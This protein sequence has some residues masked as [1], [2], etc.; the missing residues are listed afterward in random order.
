[1]DG[2][3]DNGHQRL[4]PPPYSVGGI[5]VKRH[6]TFLKKCTI[7]NV[8]Y[9]MRQNYGCNDRIHGVSLIKGVSCASVNV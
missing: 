6:D 8:M 7:Y 1:M 4:M 3:T 5:I 9:N 2:Q